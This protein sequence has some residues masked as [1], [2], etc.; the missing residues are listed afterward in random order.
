M[1]LYT[2]QL[3]QWRYVKDCNIPLVDITLRSGLEWLA[4]TPQLL[5]DYKVQ[6][7][8]GSDYSAEYT[9]IFYN[10]MRERYVADARRFID[11]IN[12]HP[13][14]C[15]ACYCGAGKFCHRHLLVDIFR[16]ICVSQNIPFE[17]VGELKRPDL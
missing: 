17:Y 9:T 5:Y 13:V 11:F 12:A 7:K 14:V 15:F 8:M 16:K 4:P 1:K 6:E 2:T 3:A 10:I